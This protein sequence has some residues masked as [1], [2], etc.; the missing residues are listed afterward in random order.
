MKVFEEARLINAHYRLKP[1]RC[2]RGE[3]PKV[4]QNDLGSDGELAARPPSAP[5]HVEVSD[6]P[7]ERF[8][9]HRYRLGQGRVG[10]NGEA[11]VSR[12]VPVSMPA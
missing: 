5:R 9:R 2:R 6:C 4:R 12:V 11:N 7:L 8:R 1:H 10:M 3:L